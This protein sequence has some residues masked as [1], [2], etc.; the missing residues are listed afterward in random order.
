MR[1]PTVLNCV[2]SRRRRDFTAPVFEPRYVPAVPDLP[3][4]GSV[5]AA[6]RERIAA[7][8]GEPVAVT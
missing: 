6:L 4:N 8:T 1:G 3:L 5:R 7:A 2:A